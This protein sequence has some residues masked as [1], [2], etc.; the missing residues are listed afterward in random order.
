MPENQIQDRGNTFDV[1][2]VTIVVVIAI[3]LSL[4]FL[5]WLITGDIYLDSYF[6]LEAFFEAQNTAASTALAQLA[7]SYS[8]PRL[9]PLLAIVIVDNLSRILIVSFILAAVIDFL[10]YA[11]IEESINELKTRLLDRHVIVCGYNELSGEFVEKLKNKKMDYVVLEPDMGK[12]AGM[13]DSR[14]LG[15][16]QDFTKEEALKLAGIGR[17]HSI[18]FASENDIDNVIGVIVARR[19]N[20]GIKIFSRLK[21]ESIRKKAHDIGVDMAVIPEHLA[22]LE[23]GDFVYRSLGR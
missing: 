16:S 12:M 13:S 15:I 5:L 7:F 1:M 8:L 19:L 18:V 17:A 20:K 14:V 21:D 11:N 9:L 6:T 4:I 3:M 23:M 10:N 22:G 2:V